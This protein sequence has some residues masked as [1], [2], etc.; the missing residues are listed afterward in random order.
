MFSLIEQG[1][2]IYATAGAAEGGCLTPA[3]DRPGCFRLIIAQADAP[4]SPDVFGHRL[5]PAGRLPS[6]AQEYARFIQGPDHQLMIVSHTLA[7][8]PSDLQGNYLPVALLAFDVDLKTL[9]AP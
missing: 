2:R 7:R 4:L 5:A 1:G 9:F 6:N 8:H 3:D